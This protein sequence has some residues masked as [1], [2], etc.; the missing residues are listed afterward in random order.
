M[1]RCF[2]V[3]KESELVKDYVTYNA[4]LDIQ[5]DFINKFF[6][7][8]AITSKKFLVSGDGSINVPFGEYNK[9]RI[10][11]WIEPTEK[12]IT[13]FGGIITKPNKYHGLCAFKSNS[14][15]AKEF[16]QKCVDEH[17]VINLYR[18]DMRDYFKSL[19][20]SGYRSNFFKHDEEFYL[21]IDSEA[22]KSEDTPTGFTEIK[23]SEYYQV[24]ETLE[25]AS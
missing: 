11:L 17:I 20:L 22:L 19:G 10:R 5:R 3:S 15:I 8:H 25:K 12:D 14:Y 23:K 2:K 6:E 9:S 18:P 1:E 16:A 21:K 4:L 7:V 13:S 24:L